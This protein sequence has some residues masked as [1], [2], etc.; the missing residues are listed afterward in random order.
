MT[1]ELTA[2]AAAPANP[3]TVRL[4]GRLVEDGSSVTVVVTDGIVAEITRVAAA[5]DA[6]WIGPSWIDLQINGAHGH[7]PN[8]ADVEPETVAGMV[9]SLWADG[10]GGSC[11]TICTES[12]ERMLRSLRAVADACDADPLIDASIVGI[13]VEGPHIA[14][15]EGPRGA[16]PPQFIRPPDVAEYRRWQDAARGRIRIITL[17]PEYDDSIP[18]IRTI[19]ADGVIPSIG[20]TAA[21]GD[22]IR[23][24]TDAGARWSTHLGNGAHA[25]ITRHPNYIWDQLSEDRLSAG[26]IFD[27][28]H[29]PP[30]VMKPFIRA[31][32]L[33]RSIL[34]SDAV[35]LAGLEPGVYELFTGM[36]VEL[37]PGG[38]LQ[39]QGTPYLAGGVAL[40][41]TCVANA[42]RHAGV[43]VGE[44]VRMVTTN[45]ARLLG[46]SPLA[47]RERVQVGAAANVTAFRVD[48][49]TSDV[50]VLTTVVDGVVVH[51]AAAA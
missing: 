45:P 38:R 29:L 43:T 35:T 42:I 24:A 19:V 50:S 17:S 18:Y 51:D 30:S 46:L 1:S 23:A 10:V 7:D 3:G 31:K 49:A 8:A 4:S 48:D 14:T 32:G 11:V 15:E 39:L 13:H 25:K 34:V 22:Q 20:H 41:P 40:L 12:E 37:T 21:T 26:F 47:G 5:P 33:E 28:Q 36:M 9:R 16:H 27:G 6:T 44:A 2:E